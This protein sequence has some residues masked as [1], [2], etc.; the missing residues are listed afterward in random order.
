MLTLSSTLVLSFLFVVAPTARAQRL[1]D[2]CDRNYN[3]YVRC[4][5][6]TPVCK[7]SDPRECYFC[8]EIE[9]RLTFTRYNLS[10]DEIQ[11]P[12]FGDECGILTKK[13][14][15]SLNI[16]IHRPTMYHVPRTIFATA[17][18]LSQSMET[19]FAQLLQSTIDSRARP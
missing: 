17:P 6:T 7:C 11:I 4:D 14:E 1:L 9:Q 15:I 3:Q 12:G 13:T 2:G 19:V 16:R 10:R 18:K 5:H 8:F